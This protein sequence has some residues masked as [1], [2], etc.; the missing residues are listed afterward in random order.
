M[1][2]SMHEETARVQSRRRWHSVAVV[3][4]DG[5]ASFELGVACTIFGDD[6]WL[7]AG[8]PWYRM[9]VC[10]AEPGPVDV[11]G[12]LQIHVSHGLE[13]IRRADTVVVLPTARIDDVP[14]EVIAALQQ[15]HARGRRIVSLCTG[16]FVL[17]RAGLLDGRRATTHWS[18]CDDL[19]RQYPRVAVDPGVLYIDEGDI[20][21][22]AGSAAS[23]DLC[24][25]VVR[26]DHGAELATQLAREMVVP[27]QRDGG[28]AQFI[29][30]PMPT[31]DST[32]LFADTVDWVQEHLHEEVTIESLAARSAM[33]PRTFA[34]RFLAATGTT[35]YQWLLRQRIH[36][37]QR[38]LETT[39]LSIDLV[40][41]RSGLGSAD[42]LRKHFSRAV[43]TNPQAYRLAF[44]DR[45]VA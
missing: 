29:D 15:A 38:L 26:Q 16:A 8:T 10:A 30:A 33:S 12:G 42:N 21:T 2:A 6:R 35:P 24:L 27:P 13:K 40:A 22:S 23:I 4:Y 34:R 9:S 14:V 19:S 18:E 5:V 17:A 39:D 32:N 7:T 3:V 41:A 45:S 20:L 25:H 31:L 28:Q 11:D 1:I 36:L 44:K 37:A 43:H